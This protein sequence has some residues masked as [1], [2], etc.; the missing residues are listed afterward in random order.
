MKV[1]EAALES[2]ASDRSLALKPDYLEDAADLL[3]ITTRNLKD[4]G[5][6]LLQNSPDTLSADEIEAIFALSGDLT[7]SSEGL[8]ILNSLILLSNHRMHEDIARSLQK[9][10]DPRSI[11]ALVETVQAD[12]DYLSWDEDKA[13]ARKCMWALATIDTKEAWSEIGRFSQIDDPVVASWAKEQLE[14]RSR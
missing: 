3:D 11:P 7:E 4:D 14:R 2:M 10:H 1:Y 12:F 8:E 5:I 6:V 9:A 13:L